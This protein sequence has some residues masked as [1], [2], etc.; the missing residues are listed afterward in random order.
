MNGRIWIIPAIAAILLAACLYGYWIGTLGKR[1]SWPVRK[2]VVLA[3]NPLLA[4]W[5][6]LFAARAFGVHISRWLILAAIVAPVPS[7]LV[8]ARRAGIPLKSVF[9][10]GDSGRGLKGRSDL[11]IR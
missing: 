1:N 11:S 5:L 10:Q 7:L 3:Y 2:I 4:I 6:I 8:A 9:I